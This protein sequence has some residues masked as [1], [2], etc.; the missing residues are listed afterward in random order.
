MAVSFLYY[1]DRLVQ[2][3]LGIIGVALGTTLLTSLSTPSILK[4]KKQTAIQFEKALKISLFFGI[5]AMLVLFIFPEIIVNSI[6]KRG[7]FAHEESKQTI[8][9]LIFYSLGVPFLIISKSC[10]AVFLASGRQ[11]KFYIFQFFNLFP[12]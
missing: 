12:I 6:F 7:N 1:A 8:L 5:P 2:L 3:P 11:T 4:D 10:Q 9:A